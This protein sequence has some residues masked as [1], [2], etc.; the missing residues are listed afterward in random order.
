MIT[1]SLEEEITTLKSANLVTGIRVVEIPPYGESYW[2]GNGNY[3]Y[4]WI[5]GWVF[6][7]NFEQGKQDFR[8]SHLMRLILI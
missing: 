5:T 4:L 7:G 2:G 3:S 1:G 6:F 8:F